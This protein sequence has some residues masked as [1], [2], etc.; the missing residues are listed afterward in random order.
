MAAG[1]GLLVAGVAT[2]TGISGAL[3]QYADRVLDGLPPKARG[4]AREVFLLL[5][6]KDGTDVGMLCNAQR[7]ERS[8]T[9]G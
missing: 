6:A 7:R 1:R 2:V 5:R 9:T 3:A 4:A 8:G